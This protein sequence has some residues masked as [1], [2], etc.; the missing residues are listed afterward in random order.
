MTAEVEERRRGERR[1]QHDRRQYRRFGL[2]GQ[3]RRHRLGRRSSDPS[4]F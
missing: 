4:P 3:D 2:Q 1:N